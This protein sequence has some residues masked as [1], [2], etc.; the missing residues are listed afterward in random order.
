MQFRCNQTAN[1]QVYL[2]WLVLGPC[3]VRGSD[4][5]ELANLVGC[6]DW[7]WNL[8]RTC[9][10][11]LSWVELE[12]VPLGI[13]LLNSLCEL[14]VLINCEE[15]R[16][17]FKYSSIWTSPFCT[18]PCSIKDQKSFAYLYQLPFASAMSLTALRCLAS[19]A[20]SCGYYLLT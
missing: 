6:G 12:T 9:I 13:V 2:V 17:A 11:L 19:L 5:D 18:W 10:A 14:V 15:V 4:L 16:R 8:C 20:C 3:L 1:L 7:H